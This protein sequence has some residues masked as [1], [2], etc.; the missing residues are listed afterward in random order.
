MEDASRGWTV[1]QAPQ[2]VDPNANDSAAL[3]FT[4][5][6]RCTC[7]RCRPCSGE[8]FRRLRLLP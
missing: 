6:V 7:Q 2:F 3:H 4:D 5:E 1:V 8:P